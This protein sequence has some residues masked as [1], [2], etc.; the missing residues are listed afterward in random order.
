MSDSLDEAIQTAETDIPHLLRVPHATCSHLINIHARCDC[1][2]G[3]TIHRLIAQGWRPPPR[4]WKNGSTI[5][6]GVRVMDEE[7]D[8]Y[9]DSGTEDWDE[10]WDSF[11]GRLVEVP[12]AQEWRQIVAQAE[13]EGR[14][15]G[16]DAE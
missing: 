5:P 12:S 11:L 6:A 10:P 4:V 2:T 3:Q 14:L 15:L 16:G 8:T 1:I 13:R 9:P 7:G